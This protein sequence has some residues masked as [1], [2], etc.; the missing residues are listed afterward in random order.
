[1]NSTLPEAS[2]AP[3]TSLIGVPVSG[4][5]DLK[6]FVSL[7]GDVHR[8]RMLCELGRGEPREVG[9]LAS[10]AGCSYQAASRHMVRL[11]RG[12]LVVQGRGRLYSLAPQFLPTAS[13]PLMNF[14][15]C[16]IPPRASG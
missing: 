9:E 3:K 16:L 12:G 2:A 6:Q 15:H 14:G 13:Q 10:V 11:R 4:A 8:W 5:G 1:M 7:I